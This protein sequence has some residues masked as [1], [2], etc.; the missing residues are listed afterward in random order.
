MS[1]E[2]Q[3]DVARSQVLPGGSTGSPYNIATNFSTSTPAFTAL[4][5]EIQAMRQWHPRAWPGEGMGDAGVSS[6]SGTPLFEGLN[7]ELTPENMRRLFARFGVQ[8]TGGFSKTQTQPFVFS[9]QNLSTQ[10]PGPA[11]FYVKDPLKERWVLPVPPSDFSVAVPNSQQSVTTISGFT[12]THAGAIELDE[13]SFDGFFPYVN[14]VATSFPKYIPSYIHSLANRDKTK[15]YAYRGPMEWVQE[16]VT[17][18]RANQPL[19]FSVYAVDENNTFTVASGSVIEPVAMSVSSFNWDMGVSV[20]GGRRDVN[21]S[22]TLKRWRR[23]SICITNYVKQ[24]ESNSSG[25]TLSG[26]SGSGKD[27]GRKRKTKKGD[28]LFAM[29]QKCLGDGHSWRLIYNLNVKK[30]DADFTAYRNLPSK[31]RKGKGRY[32]ITP[33]ITLKLPRR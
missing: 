8:K 27:C 2:G 15:P 13:I 14:A 7:L 18:M 24:D 22:I 17:A 33:G 16:L 4:V 5:A 6:K 20:G 26:I 19:L 1:G 3:I 32:P 10:F 30:I 21:Y 9:F 12:Y 28:T 11:K 23:Q 31:P 29:A 25:G